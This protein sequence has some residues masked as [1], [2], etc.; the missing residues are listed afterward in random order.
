ML[1]VA[2]VN[3]FSLSVGLSISNLNEFTTNTIKSHKWFCKRLQISDNLFSFLLSLLANGYCG[4]DNVA[5]DIFLV[6]P[7]SGYNISPHA[8]KKSWTC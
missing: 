3:P 1:T 7:T 6:F 8:D 4:T 5:V 2:K